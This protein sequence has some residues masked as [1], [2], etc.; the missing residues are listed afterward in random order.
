MFMFK[1]LVLFLIIISFSYLNAQVLNVYSPKNNHVFNDDSITFKWN[2]TDSPLEFQ[3][4]QDV[5]FGVYT[6]HITFLNEAT[7]IIPLTPG[8]YYWRVKKTG[9]TI[10][11]STKNFTLINLNLIPQ[12][13]F[14]LDPEVGI[15]HNNSNEINGWRDKISSNNFEQSSNIFKPEIVK[16]NLNS[17]D[18]VHF[19]KNNNSKTFLTTQTPFNIIDSSMTVIMNYK[20]ETTNLVSFIF[21]KASDV[22]FYVGATFQNRSLGVYD[23]TSSFW[24]TQSAKK[25]WAIASFN[26]ENLYFNGQ[27]LQPYSFVNALK[28]GPFNFEYLGSSQFT[29]NV[30]FHGDLAEI[31]IFNQELNDSTRNLVED[32]LKWKY[33]PIPNF[34]NDTVVCASEYV[35]KVPSD[36]GYSQITWSNGQT[37]VDSITATTSGTYWVTVK[38]FGLTI[39]DTIN[40]ALRSKPVMNIVTDTISCVNNG[41]YLRYTKLGP[42]QY[43]WSN[44]STA[45]TLFNLSSGTYFISQNDTAGNCILNSKAI[46]VQI[47]SFSL[48]STLGPDRNFC[49]G[50]N[51]ELQ[52]TTSGNEPYK[53]IWSTLDTSSFIVLNTPIATLIS[54]KVTDAYGCIVRDTI[55]ANVINLASPS[56]DFFS[57]TVCFGGASSFFSN[58]VASGTDIINNYVWSFPDNS[59]FSG[60]DSSQ[61]THFN[62]TTYNVNLT[63]QTDSNCENSITKP[64]YL[65]KLPVVN[66]NQEIVCANNLKAFNENSYTFFPDKLLNYNWYINND[67]VSN[68]ADPNLTFG[69]VGKQEL[70]LVVESEFGCFNELT[71]TIEVFPGLDADFSFYNNCLGDSVSFTDQTVSFSVVDWKW[72]FNGFANS[73]L[74][75]P[76]RVFNTVGAQQIKLDVENAIGCKS[77]IIKTVNIVAQPIA[78][79]GF[80]KICME[81]F[82]LF[83]D[84]STVLN[85]SIISYN[86]HIDTSFYAK[87]SVQHK[88]NA[89]KSFV[90]SLNI[91]T[92]NG[93]KDDTMATLTVNP[94]PIPDFDF[95]PNYG[96]AP[97]EVSF[98]NKTPNTTLYSWTFGDAV[99]VSADENP[100]YTYLQNGIYNI[101]LSATNQFNCNA[102]TSQQINVIPSDLDIELKNLKFDI[103]EN[104][105]N[106]ISINPT[107]EMKNVG[108]RIINS[109]DLVLTLNKENSFVQKWEGNIAIGSATNYVFD[110]YYLVSDLANSKYVCIEAINVN[111][112]TEENFSN[113]KVCKLLDGLVQISKPYPNPTRN[114]VFIDIITKEKGSCSVQVFNLLGEIIVPASNIDLKNGYN[115]IGI[116]TSLYQSGKYIVMIKYLDENYSQQFVL[117]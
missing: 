96:T 34:G 47:D 54:V 65:H 82:S 94:S 43:T 75:N 90:A 102:S 20:L 86:W 101:T 76:K 35:L 63:V 85:D 106:T 3:I 7:L 62:N 53:Y 11:S 87:D 55:M 2:K 37:N 44:G 68:A 33:T 100:V 28:I 14:W 59:F 111:D 98:Q 70:K 80:D 26:N 78:S 74:Q 116:E 12:L 42:F 18:Y 83:Y 46:N 23:G 91:E 64:V 79:F 66:F 60:N 95:T 45:D 32:Y 36:H 25:E 48:Q 19:G 22:G 17:H 110:G 113:N 105:D 1:K 51:L 38:S 50:S 9:S 15:I 4:S 103:Q 58:A 49:L 89:L 10:W 73:S 21:S 30:H 97:L 109:A 39:T 67:L 88:F 41:L 24:K 16:N 8:V 77:S 29:N 93:C 27:G 92:I 40:I 72:T 52:T 5:L 115:K 112:K 57:D 13:D 31:L 84:N 107:V 114:N 69:S 99:G 71:D 56:I 81:D 108:T 117:E 61:Y 104:A 6:N